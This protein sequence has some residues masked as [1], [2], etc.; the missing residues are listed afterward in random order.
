MF[1]GGECWIKD[2]RGVRSAPAVEAEQMRSTVQRD[3][4]ALL[5]ALA[6]GKVPATRLPDV[7]ERGR[8]LTALG[9]GGGAMQA[10]VLILDPVTDLILAQRYD[11]PVG[12]I[13]AGNDGRAVLGVPKRRRPAGRIRCR[14]AGGRPSGVDAPRALLRYN[15]PLA[16][17][18]FT[19][20][21]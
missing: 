16:A 11:A 19:R 13:G 17:D 21:S 3:V 10:V 15:V 14:R 18:L 5:L 20:P 1:S 12:A 8:G 7:V 2:D 6:D 9:V 4:I